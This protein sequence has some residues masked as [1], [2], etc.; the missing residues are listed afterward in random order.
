VYDYTN[1]SNPTIKIVFLY[2][3]RLNYLPCRQGK[4]QDP[5][6]YRPDLLDLIFFQYILIKNN[7]YK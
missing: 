3:A 4:I 5:T 1:S 2:M 7:K 6:M